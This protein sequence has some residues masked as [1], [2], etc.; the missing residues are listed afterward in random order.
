MPEHPAEPLTGK[1][2]LITG[3]AGQVALPITRA[4][5]R[6]NEVIGVARF[7]DAEVK[8]ELEGLGVTCVPVDLA[9]G[10]FGDVP[11]DVDYVL[12]LA[13]VKSNRWDVD[14]RGNAEATGLLMAHCRSATAFLHC[15]STGVYQHAGATSSSRPT[16]SATTTG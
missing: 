5:A 11:D 16:R 4:L 7:R 10:D 9:A 13:V 12:N 6:T 15:S 14:L 1:K 8:S 3:P 2:I